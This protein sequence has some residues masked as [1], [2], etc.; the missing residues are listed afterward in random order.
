MKD[1]YEKFACVENVQAGKPVVLQPG[2][3]WTATTVMNV[4]E[5][6]KK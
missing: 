3:S 1:S 4:V 5:A 6:P 2:Q